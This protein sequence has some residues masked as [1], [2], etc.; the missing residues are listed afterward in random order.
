[1]KKVLLFTIMICNIFSLMAQ[2]AP[3]FTYDREKINLIMDQITESNPA[4]SWCL[5][6]NPVKVNSTGLSNTG[7]FFIG[8][9]SGCIGSIGGLLLSQT[10][11]SFTRPFLML[12]GG[13]LAGTAIA[14]LIVAGK[15]NGKSKTMRTA[16]GGVSGTAALVA[17][18]YLVFSQIAIW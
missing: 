6:Q 1:M 10:N 4:Q 9:G 2:Q 11:V 16:I 15:N 3:H 13:G 14:V 8:F 5:T 17:T 18:L 12:I 7:S